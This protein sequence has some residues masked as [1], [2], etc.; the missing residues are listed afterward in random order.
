MIKEI[1]FI[2]EAK[3]YFQKADCEKLVVFDVDMVLTHCMHPAFQMPNMR[4][5]RFI[6][7][8]MTKPLSPDERNLFLNLMGVK[9]GL[10]L[11]EDQAPKVITELQKQGIKT[12]A[13]TGALSG[14][15]AEVKDMVK[16]RFDSLQNFGID[17]SSSFPDFQEILFENFP[18]SLRSFPKFYRGI[19]FTNG[20]AEVTG[21][22]KVLIS[23]L[24]EVNSAPRQI[25]FLDDRK[26]N[27]RDVEKA[28]SEFDP[29]VEFTGLHYKGA[30][31]YPSE[32]ISEEEFMKEWKKLSQE[33][34]QECMSLNA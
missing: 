3:E 25:V 32:A 14:Q 8:D 13:L 28:L 22:G 2:D 4:E 20:D 23:F 5:H 12:I 29:N 24:K 19:L 11:I 7:R 16:W 17:F 27:L 34:K 18:E 21:K 31:A 30:L 10:M 15:L 1:H 26:D 9:R 6:A 33:A